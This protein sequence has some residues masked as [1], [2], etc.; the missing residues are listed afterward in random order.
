MRRLFTTVK[1]NSSIHIIEGFKSR[2]SFDNCT[3]M[4]LA[5]IDSWKDGYSVY[6]GF[7]PTSDRLHLGN[8]F[9]VISLVRASLHG[10]KPI[11]LVGGA[12]GM[13]G[14]PSGKSSERN[15]LENDVL[16]YNKKSVSD[17]LQSLVSSISTHLNSN[18]AEYKLQETPVLP[19]GLFL[20]NID[21]YKD[22]NVLGFLSQ[23]GI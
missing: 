22:M 23:V 8:L 5:R 15:M 16:E 14:D 11:Y 18:R 4:D 2:H 9:Q 1:A 7:D 12:T 3:S 13:I 21:F 17:N 19:Q 10:F 20:D 6:A